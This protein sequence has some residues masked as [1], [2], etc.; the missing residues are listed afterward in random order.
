VTAAGGG[1]GRKLDRGDGSSRGMRGRAQMHGT[2]AC[3]HRDHGVVTIPVSTR[4]VHDVVVTATADAAV[5]VVVEIEVA[6]D[7]VQGL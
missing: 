2:K 4:L 3:S 6:G 1:R 5:E 7:G